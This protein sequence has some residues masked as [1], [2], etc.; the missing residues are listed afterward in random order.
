MVYENDTLSVPKRQVHVLTKGK[1]PT[2]APYSDFRVQSLLGQG[3][4]AQVFRCLHIQTGQLVAVKIVKNKPAYTRQ[5]AV[6]I[7]VIRALTTTA[8]ENDDDNEASP[9]SLK[10][11]YMVDMVCY[12]MYK[13][14][15]CLVFEMLGLNLYEVLKKRQFRGLP[16][17]VTQ[18]LV[19]QAVL[20]ARGLAQKSIVHCDLKPENIL[21]VDEDDAESVMSAGESKRLLAVS[22]LSN[23]TSS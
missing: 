21:L 8:N 6:E 2:G 15:L 23:A 18:T 12:F 3:T 17:T 13:D 10:N 5:A 20:G 14:H 9:S 19:R 7:D 22:F 4:F 16:L 1:I 11:D